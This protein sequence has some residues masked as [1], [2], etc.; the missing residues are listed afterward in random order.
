MP[1][2]CHFSMTTVT[3]RAI[4]C[5]EMGLQEPCINPPPPGHYPSPLGHYPSTRHTYP[6]HPEPPALPLSVTPQS[7]EPIPLLPPIPLRLSG[8]GLCRLLGV[9]ADAS[10]SDIKSAY[11]KA[12]LKTHPDVSNAPDATQ[13]FSQL[14]SAY[15]EFLAAVCRT[16]PSFQY[17]QAH[18]DGCSLVQAWPSSIKIVCALSGQ[19]YTPR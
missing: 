8:Y 19:S 9:A 1:K 7:A 3:Q 6:V 10:L 11:R 13:Q 4:N 14:S 5:T 2:S 18:I 16:C 12:A 17:L 15:G